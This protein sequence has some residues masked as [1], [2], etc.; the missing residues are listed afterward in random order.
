VK[1]DGY[2]AAPGEDMRLAFNVVSPDYFT[3]MRIGRIAGREFARSDSAGGQ[4]AVIV[5][6]T[7][8]RRFWGSPQAAV[9][10]QIRIGKP[11]RAR[12]VVGVVRDIKYLSLT[13]RPQAY[14]YLP[15]AQEVRQEMMI[16]ARAPIAADRLIAQVRGTIGELDPNL[17]VVSA[18]PMA[19][20]ARVGTFLY[21]AVATGLGLFGLL[22]M[23]LAGVGI[24]GLVAYTVRQR[25]HEIG[26][27]MALGAS[28]RDVIWRFLPAGIWLGS[29]GALIGVAT[30][31]AGTRM[32]AAM[33]FG[34]SATD[35][36]AF[37]SAFVLVLG[38]SALASFLPAWR[39][40]RISPM[41]SL[42][43]H[44]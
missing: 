42:Q 37:G 30:A 8:A 1:I 13:E 44:H 3:T 35:P 14:F 23:S 15:L 33:L 22:S 10:R 27:C 20:Y 9:G 29:I 24:Y 34:V 26:L 18:Q 6:E 31:L 40:S 28:R 25:R 32:M 2:A 38:V 36:V 19:A 7:M 21:E 17:P 5:N 4:A 39:A 11:D 41:S 12:A 16:V 43:H